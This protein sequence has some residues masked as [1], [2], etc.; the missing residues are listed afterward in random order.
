M[1][2]TAGSAALAVLEVRVHLDL[3]FELL[4]VDYSLM[5]IE[6]GDGR[7]EE[8]PLQALENAC[9]FG[10]VWLTEARSP[11]LR[12][13]SLIVPEEANFLINPRHPEATNIAL[14]SKRVFTFDPRL[15]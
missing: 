6:L 12:V 2:Y 11:V 3:P 15:F 1:L 7:I 8:A 14:I 5:S 4:P 10:D 9:Q 13:P